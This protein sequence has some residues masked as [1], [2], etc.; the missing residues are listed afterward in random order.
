MKAKDGKFRLTDTLD[1]ERIFRLI[2]SKAE[3][4][5]QTNNYRLTIKIIINNGIL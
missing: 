5:L 3:V 1:I 4:F 2:E